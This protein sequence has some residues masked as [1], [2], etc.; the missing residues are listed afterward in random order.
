M[1]PFIG[2]VLCACCHEGAASTTAPVVGDVFVD[3]ILGI[4]VG[5]IGLSVGVVL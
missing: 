3:I 4:P 5:V 2:D 1:F